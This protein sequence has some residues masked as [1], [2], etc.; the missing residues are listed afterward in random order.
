VAFI[1]NVPGVPTDPS[2]ALP[3]QI[4]LWA[5]SAERGFVEKTAA[6]IMVII[7]FLIAMNLLAV[8]IRNRTR[9]SNK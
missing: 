9:I 1:A 2:T 3:V 7:V 6:A 8:L 5:E 4:Y